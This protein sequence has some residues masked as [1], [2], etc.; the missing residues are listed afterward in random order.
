MAI[1]EVRQGVPH[2]LSNREVKQRIMKIRGWTS[3]EYENEYDKLRN[4]IR[5]YEGYIRSIGGVKKEEQSPVKILY[6]QAKAMKREGKNYTP[7]IELKTI[8]SFP[9]VSTGKKLQKELTS[10]KVIN[11]WGKK[12][13]EAVDKKFRGFINANPLAKELSKTI[14]NPVKLDFALR[15]LLKQLNMSISQSEANLSTS[16]IPFGQTVGSKDVIDFDISKYL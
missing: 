4:R 1:F 15:D 10:S 16:A 14:E 3:K 13:G 2:K 5:A 8:L 6:R 7:S 12:Y 11:E 9:T